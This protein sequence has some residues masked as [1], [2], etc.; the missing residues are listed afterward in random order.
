RLPP[1]GRR[2]PPRRPARRG[3]GAAAPGGRGPGRRPAA[4]HGPRSASPLPSPRRRR[5]RAPGRGHREV[6]V[7]LPLLLA[8]L[9]CE[10][11]D[12]ELVQQKRA[13]N[14]WRDGK[15]HLEQGEAAEAAADFEKALEERPGDPLLQAWLAQ[16]L[17]EQGELDRAI[18]VL[19]GVLAEHPDFAEA[20][21]NRASYLARSGDPEA[22]A[23]DLRRAL[24]DGARQPRDVLEDPD[25]QR[26]L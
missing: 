22:A 23:A 6:P 20:R 4:L 7:I 13:L 3:P 18:A 24:D 10:R 2:P 5:V 17:A 12:P 14:A 1:P 16:A 9:A 15:E 25:F 19:D 11:P 8:L 26:Y 21:Y